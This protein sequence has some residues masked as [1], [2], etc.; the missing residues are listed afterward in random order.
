MTLQDTLTTPLKEL[1]KSHLKS[2]DS[3]QNKVYGNVTIKENPI[4]MENQQ[5]LQLTFM[6]E[7]TN[8][9]LTNTLS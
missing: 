5:K 4:N 2:T 9:L 3:F 8:I 7:P 1:R 6:T